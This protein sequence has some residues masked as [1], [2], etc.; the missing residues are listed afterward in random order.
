MAVNV[1]GFYLKV[2]NTNELVSFDML[3][4]MLILSGVLCHEQTLSVSVIFKTG[5]EKNKC[6]HTV[7][8]NLRKITLVFFEPG[9]YVSMFWGVNV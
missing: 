7:S 3:C 6:L 1:T 2:V 4:Y 9:L 8:L 5:E